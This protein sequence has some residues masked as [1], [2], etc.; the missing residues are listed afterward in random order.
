V[1]LMETGRVVAQGTLS[2]VSLRPE[3]RKIVGPDAVGSVLDGVVTKTDPARAMADMQLGNS[4]LQV[5]ARDVTI[6][7]RLR[8]HLL[9]RDIILATEKPHSL[10]V[11]NTLNGIVVEVSPDDDDAMLVKVDIGGAIVLSRITHD[12]A[13]ALS[14]HAGSAVWVLVKAVSTRGHA[15]RAPTV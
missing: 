9:A 11:R 15:Y 2:E 14:L 13:E 7:S 5:S 4:T 12:A 8:V 10:S 6:G 3:L 1:V